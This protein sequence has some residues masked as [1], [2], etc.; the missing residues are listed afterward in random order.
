MADGSTQGGFNNSSKWLDKPKQITDN[1]D[2][3]PSPESVAL[4]RMTTL[5]NGVTTST[6]NELRDL[7]DEIDNLMRV[8]QSR[9]NTIQGAFVEHV[10]FAADAIKC[11][12]IIK[13]TLK[14]I[15]TNF[16]NGMT[17]IAKNVTV[18]SNG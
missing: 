14:R 16:S 5:V 12:A 17:P 15:N 2:P 7:R 10:N 13:D 9:N 3:A 18:Q 11:K 6:M 8:I 4:E 1:G